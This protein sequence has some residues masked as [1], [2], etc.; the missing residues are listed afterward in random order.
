M[1]A[2]ASQATNTRRTSRQ[3]PADIAAR[4]QDERG[5]VSLTE[6]LVTTPLVLLVL[7]A[8]FVLYNQ[9]V[10]GQSRT[11]SRVRGLQQQQIGLEK[12]SRELRQATSINPSSSQLVDVITYVT[13]SGG[14]AAS[15]R[16]VRYDCAAGTCNRWEGPPPLTG[17]LTAGPVPVITAVQNA[18]VFG[19]QPDY[20]NPNFVALNVNVTISGAQN[21][22]SLSGGVA[23]KNLSRDN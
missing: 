20:V 2:C 10:K 21:P 19:M 16:H 1:S 3:G 12:I 14:S 18:D 6:L 8:V 23:L 5:A 15:A 9:G 17:A 7:G 22:I 11:D 13:P 4:L